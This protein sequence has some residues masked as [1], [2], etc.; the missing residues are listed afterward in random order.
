MLEF[1]TAIGWSILFSNFSHIPLLVPTLAPF[2]SARWKVVDRHPVVL[3]ALL[4]MPPDHLLVELGLVASAAGLGTP[5]MMGQYLGNL[6]HSL[7]G[8][9]NTTCETK[10]HKQP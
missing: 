1:V 9:T 7:T 8:T 4:K 6:M 2:A 10:H 3:F 5:E